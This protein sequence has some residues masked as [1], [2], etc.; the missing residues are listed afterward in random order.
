LNGFKTSLL[1]KTQPKTF[2]GFLFDEN[3]SSSFFSI[4]LAKL[5]IYFLESIEFKSILFLKELLILLINIVFLTTLF[6]LFQDI[7][8]II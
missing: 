5:K 6:C 2:D 4:F 7:F 1:C 8:N 3:F